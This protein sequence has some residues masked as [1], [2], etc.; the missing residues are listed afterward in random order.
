MR[1]TIIVTKK[2]H[3]GHINTQ[4][5][6]SFVYR[7]KVAIFVAEIVLSAVLMCTKLSQ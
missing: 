2:N 1:A 6:H 5:G 7:V 4:S 3:I